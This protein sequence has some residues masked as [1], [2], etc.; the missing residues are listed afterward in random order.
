MANRRLLAAIGAGSA[1]LVAASQVLFGSASAA[2]LPILPDPST[3]AATSPTTSSAGF[4][5]RATSGTVT[6]NGTTI[7]VSVNDPALPEGQLGLYN[8]LWGNQLAVAPGDDHVGVVVINGIVT[9]RSSDPLGVPLAGVVLVA[10]G[11]AA[12]VLNT[13]TV[14]STLTIDLQID[15]AQP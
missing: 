2:P 14:G 15:P 4:A 13:A 8:R 10:S 12:D 11:D 1:A 5:L 7:Q 9:H 3:P 6:I